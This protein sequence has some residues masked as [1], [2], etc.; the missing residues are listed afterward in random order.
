MT[1]AAAPPPLDPAKWHVA[2]RIR[3]RQLMLVDALGDVRNLRLAADMLHTTIPAASRLLRQLEDTMGVPLFERH[4]EGLRPN[5]HGDIMIRY[6]RKVLNDLAAVRGEIQ[7]VAHGL[8]GD[9]RIGT[10]QSTANLILPRS[11]ASLVREYPSLSV[12]IQEG[13]MHM[14]LDGLRRGSLDLVIGR[15]MTRARLDDLTYQIITIEYFS[16]IAPAHHPLARARRVTPQECVDQPWILPPRHIPLRNLIDSFFVRKAGRAPARVIESVSVHTNQALL[17]ELNGLGIL[18]TNTALRYQDEGQLRV[19]ALDLGEIAGPLAI[20]TPAG[21]T[22]H[23]GVRA[24]VQR[25]E[26]LASGEG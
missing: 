14:L 9:L 22:L 4:R 3:L 11:I 8:S 20:I 23:R 26:Q 2:S 10:V 7:A 18:P 12:S 24:L 1:Q 13:E 25:I 6:A 17:R 5:L 19:V 16:V 21:D 15:G